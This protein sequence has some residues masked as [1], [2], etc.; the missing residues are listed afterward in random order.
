M[1]RDCFSISRLS[2]LEHISEVTWALGLSWEE[3][4]GVWP[5]MRGAPRRFFPHRNSTYTVGM[6]TPTTL[7]CLPDY[8]IEL[9]QSDDC[10]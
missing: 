2:Y 5:P 3:E 9:R 4:D 6:S 1:E 10:G 8:R 7:P